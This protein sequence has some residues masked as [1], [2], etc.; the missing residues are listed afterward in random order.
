MKIFKE[1]KT[2]F[3][4]NVKY[5]R[6]PATKGALSYKHWFSRNM[7]NACTLKVVTWTNS[8]G[9]I[10]SVEESKYYAYIGSEDLTCLEVERYRNTRTNYYL[11]EYLTPASGIF[12]H[13]KAEQ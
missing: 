6:L 3:G 1:I 7:C 11:P 2:D 5:Y 10:T 8:D 4:K 9:R 12:T 13:L